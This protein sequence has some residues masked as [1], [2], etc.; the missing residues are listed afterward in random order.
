[1]EFP[2]HD[3]KAA[4]FQ[5]EGMP[6][7]STYMTFPLSAFNVASDPSDSTSGWNLITIS[8]YFIDTSASETPNCG[9]FTINGAKSAPLYYM[10]FNHI[11]NPEDIIT[12]WYG[13]LLANLFCTIVGNVR[14]QYGGLPVPYTIDINPL[15]LLH[16]Q[17]PRWLGNFGEYFFMAL[18]RPPGWINPDYPEDSDGINFGVQE[19][20]SSG[21]ARNGIYIS[22][23]YHYNDD[24]P[25]TM[26]YLNSVTSGEI[27]LYEG[28]I[29]YS[30]AEY[31][32]FLA[33]LG[34]VIPTVAIYPEVRPS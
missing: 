12:C 3:H 1:M 25:N 11:S 30:D 5:L 21:L 14:G 4:R 24:V 19:L 15:V 6:S 23:R 33:N 26:T 34:S 13:D 22:G 27:R 8:A 32:Q 2:S 9:Y 16:G 7:S 10:L 18:D 17:Y 31:E 20:K 29:G 28:K